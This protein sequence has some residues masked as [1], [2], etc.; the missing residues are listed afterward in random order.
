MSAS[1]EDVLNDLVAEYDRLERILSSL[2]DEQ[3]LA[4]SG[5]PGWTVRDVVVHL[6]QTEEAVAVSLAEPVAEWT[7]R[8][9]SLDDAVGHLPSGQVGE[10]FAHERGQAGHPGCG[11]ARAPGP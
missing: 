8:D 6:A 1:I 3:W 2:D 5:A 10:A 11:E 7:S 4:P 9:R